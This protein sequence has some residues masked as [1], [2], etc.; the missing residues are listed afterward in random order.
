MLKSKA[1]DI[2]KTFSGL[3]FSRFKKFVESPY[4][5]NNSGI[6][7]LVY[8]L[9]SFHPDYN[10]ADL[11]EEYL[12]NKV[13]KTDKFSYSLMRNLMSELLYLSESFLLNNRLNKDILK[14]PANIIELLDELQNRDISNHFK[15]RLKN[16]EKIISKEKFDSVHYRNNV[17]LINFILDDEYNKVTFKNNLKDV[18]FKKAIFE[19]CFIAN[20]LYR[21]ANSIHFISI[22]NNVKADDSYFFIFLKCIDINKFLSEMN[23][24]RTSESLIIEIYF[25]LIL[26]ILNPGDLKNYFEVK[27]LIFKNIKKFSNKEKYSLLNVLRNYILFQYAGGENKLKAEQRIINL[28]ML[29]SIDFKKDKMESILGIIFI[30]IFFE[31]VSGNDL[32]YAENF[33]NKYSG[34]LRKEIRKDI[35]GFASAYILFAKKD[36]E[37]SLEKLLHVKPPNKVYFIHIKHLYIRLYYELGYYD[38][39]LS[40]I[41]T[42]RH[43]LDSNK[44]L[45]QEKKNYF[46]KICRSYHRLFRLK[47]N[48]DKYSDFDVTKFMKELDADVLNNDTKWI[49][50]KLS[51]LN[52]LMN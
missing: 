19:L 37:G 11:S 7:R 12:Y 47:M 1:I 16:A 44:V 42:Y 48:S 2:I 9:E 20:S 34:Q 41:D 8:E 27:N 13:Y 17:Q 15:L 43:Y 24:L 18:F 4:F 40:V 49:F 52:K 51:D 32:K 22:E 35:Y 39:G 36:Y 26:L 23:R 45:N 31:A 5:N 28:E 6:I 50:S 21:N 29:D 14:N 46:L 10:S 30:G 25:K 33:I 3:E 38:E